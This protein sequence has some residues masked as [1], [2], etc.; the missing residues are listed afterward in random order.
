MKTQKNNHGFTLIEVIVSLV[1]IGILAT[2]TSIGVGKV[3]QGYL[4]TKDN[5]NTTLKAQIAL[6]RLMKEF[7]SIDGVTSG[8]QTSITYS[9]IKNGVSIPNRTIS[10]SGTVNDPLM[11]G[12]NT[13]TEDVNDF[14][15]SY[16]EDYNDAG[17]NTWN[18]SEKIIGVTLKLTGAME[19]VSSFSICITPR[20]L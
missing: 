12:G 16:H 14:E 3:F 1:I 13:L 2:I 8:S 5:A 18:G 10:W 19:V 11:L 15:L 17:D 6:T 20:N 4:F 7:N 9:Y